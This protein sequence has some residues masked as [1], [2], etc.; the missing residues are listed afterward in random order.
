M[1]WPT[2]WQPTAPPPPF[3][4]YPPLVGAGGAPPAAPCAT[5]FARLVRCI[6]AKTRDGGCVEPY[7]LLVRCLRAHGLDEPAP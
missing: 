7:R 4:L 5:E 2:Q 3:A 6:Q 1:M